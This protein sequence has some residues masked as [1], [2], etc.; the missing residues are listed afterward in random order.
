MRTTKKNKFQR[1]VTIVI[2]LLVGFFLT[3][4]RETKFEQLKKTAEPIKD[5]SCSCTTEQQ[6]KPLV[7]QQTDTKIF[8]VDNEALERVSDY[9]IK[10]SNDLTKALNHLE[11]QN[12]IDKSFLYVQ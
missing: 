2:F 4:K 5:T 1:N 9:S 3:K 8:V 10:N 12:I 11:Q 7:K 6:I